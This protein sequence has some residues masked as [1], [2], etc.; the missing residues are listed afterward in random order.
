LIIVVGIPSVAD[1]FAVLCSSL[2]HAFCCLVNRKRVSFKKETK[3]TNT[4]S[5]HEHDPNVREMRMQDYLAYDVSHTLALLMGADPNGCFDN[6][7]DLFLRYFP[8]VFAALGTLWEGWYVVDLDEEVVINEHC[9]A[10]LPDQTI[11]D[12]TV[13][14]LVPPS[15]SVYYFPGVSRSWQEVKD[16]V[17]QKKDVW[18]P[19]VRGSGRYGEDGFG[20]PSYKAAYEAARSKVYSL[21]QAAS[22]PK[23]MTFLQAR[24]LDDDQRHER[25]SVL[26]IITADEEEHHR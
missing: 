15:Q 7:L 23:K 14:L 24:D 3:V 2:R 17:Q 19:Y 18:F 10:A 9:W 1:L 13:T 21:A 4:P 22:P 11:I 8:D 12:P 20:H 25:T 6:I 16:L 26:I 5:S